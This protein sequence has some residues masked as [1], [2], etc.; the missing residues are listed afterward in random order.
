[1][2]GGFGWTQSCCV[3]VTGT[4]MELATVSIAELGPVSADTGRQNEQTEPIAP[5]RPLCP[6]A[7]CHRIP[8]SSAALEVQAGGWHKRR[9]LGERGGT[10]LQF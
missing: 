3:V 4:M 6:S 5:H 10:L 2:N 1:M 9:G 8:R 7:P